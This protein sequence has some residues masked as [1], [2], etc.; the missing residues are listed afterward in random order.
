[1]RHAIGGS[2]ARDLYGPVV[3]FFRTKINGIFAR[4]RRGHHARLNLVFTQHVKRRRG[5]QH[6]RRSHLINH[7]QFSVNDHRRC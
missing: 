5:P 7:D 3:V 1:M 4:R 6:P 2:R